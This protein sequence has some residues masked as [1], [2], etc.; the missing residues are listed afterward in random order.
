MRGERDGLGSG[1]TVQVGFRAWRQL[2]IVETETS[3]LRA[4][5]ETGFGCLLSDSP[6]PLHPKLPCNPEGRRGRGLQAR[7]LMRAFLTSPRMP[8]TVWILACMYLFTCT[9]RHRA[10]RLSPEQP[11]ANA[12]NLKPTPT[13]RRLFLLSSREAAFC[14]LGEATTTT[15]HQGFRV[16]WLGGRF[17]SL[18]ARLGGGEGKRGRAAKCE[19]DFTTEF[20]E[21]Q[22][23][24]FPALNA[25]SGN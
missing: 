9:L 4:C 15:R 23:L 12:L 8:L 1:L 25:N 24:C 20:R 5:R 22:L 17:R 13:C 6:V 7:S 21:E 2:S 19:K 3:K 11:L 14:E 16:E 18:G 10:L